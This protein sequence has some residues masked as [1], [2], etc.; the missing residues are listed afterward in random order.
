MVQTG[1]YVNVLL[2]TRKGCGFFVCLSLKDEI[3]VNLQDGIMGFDG[4]ET[5]IKV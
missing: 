3:R 4:Y 5:L 1:D 2:W